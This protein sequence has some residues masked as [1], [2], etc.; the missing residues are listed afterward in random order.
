[1]QE[2][3]RHME[4]FKIHLEITNR[5]I[6]QTLPKPTIYTL[7]L[8]YYQTLYCYVQ[9][10]TIKSVTYLGLAIRLCHEL[11][12]HLRNDTPIYSV[13]DPSTQFSLKD[14]RRVLTAT[15]LLSYIQD[16][17][18]QAVSGIPYSTHCDFNMDILSE[19]KDMEL[20]PSQADK[21]KRLMI[22]ISITLYI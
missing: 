19:Y 3:F 21:Y 10:Q 8:T 4:E 18:L 6:Y 13:K 15:W 9:Q 14:T 17:Y 16:F 5:Y 11:E 1:M 20:D 2:K 7:I 12:L 22:A